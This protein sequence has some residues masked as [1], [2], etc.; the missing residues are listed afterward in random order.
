M[1]TEKLSFG[2]KKL[3][4]KFTCSEKH[5][6]K[7]RLTKGV[8]VAKVYVAVTVF[9]GRAAPPPRIVTPFFLGARCKPVNWIRLVMQGASIMYFSSSTSP[10]SS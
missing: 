7:T 5:S 10:A 1:Y 4:K 8:V 9:F 6:S 2:I 3:K